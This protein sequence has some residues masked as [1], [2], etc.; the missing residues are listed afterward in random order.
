MVLRC[1]YVVNLL[2]TRALQ[3]H[4]AVVSGPFSISN[5]TFSSVLGRAGVDF[6]K[7]GA[8]RLTENSAKIR[9]FHVDLRPD[10]D[11]Y[12][13]H[14]ANDISIKMM[15]LVFAVYQCFPLRFQ[16]KILHY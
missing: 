14:V 3:C 16:S 2:H 9:D 10:N 12:D 7:G 15:N 5:L 6:S 1:S 8:S 4:V 11:M 13:F